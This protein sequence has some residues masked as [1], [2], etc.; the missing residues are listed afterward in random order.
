MP[1]EYKTK[2]GKTTLNPTYSANLYTPNAKEKTDAMVD[3]LKDRGA[4]GQQ[5]QIAK[6]YLDGSRD[7]SMAKLKHYDAAKYNSV[8]QK[9]AITR[10]CKADKQ[11]AYKTN[12]AYDYAGK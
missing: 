5:K 1:R 8:K 6:A 7:G 4:S 3:V 10:K 9:M 12:K 11:K 2:N